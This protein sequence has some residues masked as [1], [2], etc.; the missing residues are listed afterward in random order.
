MGALAIP[1]VY[2]E[3]TVLL[4]DDEPEYLDWL[5]DFLESLG[6]KVTVAVNVGQAMAACEKA[7]F[8]IYIIDLNIPLGGW[9][10]PT[11]A[12]FSHYCGLSIIQAIRSQGNDGRRVIA[13]SAHTN[14]E[15]NAEMRRLYTDF[16]EKD[17]AIQL[18]DRLREL[19]EQPDQT[20]AAL[21]RVNERIT[22]RASA[23]PTSAT[24]SKTCKPRITPSSRKKVSGAKSPTKP[25]RSPPSK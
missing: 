21:K 18:K 13:Y 1:V 5:I 17:H 2:D 4:A 11:N 14:A 16:I 7:W 3:K 23:K 19:L 25:L 20:A 9:P 12:T 22:K 10:E 8:R 15:I 24:A 6:L